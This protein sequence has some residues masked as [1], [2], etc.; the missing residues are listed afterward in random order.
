MSSLDYTKLM[1]M[2]E[3]SS[4][5][6]LYRLYRAIDRELENPARTARIKKQLRIGMK[7]TYFCGR[8]N[9]LFDATVLELRRTNALLLNHL[10]QKRWVTPYYMLNLDGKE[11]DIRPGSKETLSANTVRVGDRVG[12]VSKHGK[13]I[14][15]VVIRLNRKTVTIKT[16]EDG[17]WRVHYSHLYRVY[18]G[19]VNTTKAIEVEV[20]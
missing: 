17:Q 13:D 18:D 20:G 11:V 19:E 12:F 4:T 5:F 1:E 6:D 7:L 8:T 3:Q 15:G 9:R 2:L 10:D 16:F 14:V